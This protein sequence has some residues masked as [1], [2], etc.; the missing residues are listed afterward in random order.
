MSRQATRR[1]IGGYIPCGGTS[2][3]LLRK[4]GSPMAK[5]SKKP[6]AKAKPAKKSVTK[7]PV[8]K[9]PATKAAVKKPAAPAKL[10]GMHPVTTGQGPSALEVGKDMVSMFNRG[11]LAEI[12]AKY[13]SS[14][15]ASIEGLGVNM[16]WFGRKA[17]E[18]K[19][20]GW[21]ADHVIHG[22]AAEGP[23]VGSSGFAIRFKMDIETKSTGK[24]EI[25]DEIGVY[26][27]QN[28]KIVRE[29][30]MYGV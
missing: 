24:R 7:K 23:F 5:K 14:E 30:F 1:A 29:E 25:I 6:A 28:G 20:A 9:A 12:E 3:I 17:V 19:N 10:V 27:I 8:Q 4:K 15:I 26:Q 11:Q 16:G 18:E 21:M 2:T 22:A 13:W